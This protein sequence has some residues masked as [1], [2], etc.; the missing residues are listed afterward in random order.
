MIPG[1][2]LR[3]GSESVHE[4]QLALQRKECETYA[5]AS[6]YAMYAV[7]LCKRMHHQLLTLMPKIRSTVQSRLGATKDHCHQSSD[8]FTAKARHEA[9]AL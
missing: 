2:S 8:N 7:H 4:A 9:S 5:Y 3:D 6:S 1:R